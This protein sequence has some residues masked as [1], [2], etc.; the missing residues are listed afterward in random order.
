MSA[1]K[2]PL[3]VV[4]L[5]SWYPTFEDSIKGN[6]FKEQAQGLLKHGV[7]IGV[8]YPEIRS[9]KDLSFASVLKNHFQTTIE[10]ENK[11]PT[12]RL[13]GWNLFP[14]MGK[15][16]MSAW[17]KHALKLMDNYVQKRGKPELIHAHSVMWGGIAA[18]AIA[19]K[20]HIPYMI[21]EH[22]TG[23]Q[24][25]NPL[26]SPLNA[27]WSTPYLIS[28]Y[29]QASCVLAVGCALKK[30]IESFVDKEVQV[31][32]NFFDD[33]F[34]SLKPAS[35]FQAP[36]RY[37]CLAQLSPTK[38]YPL[39]LKAFQKVHAYNNRVSLEI[40]GSGKIRGQLEALAQELGIA[41][42]VKFLGGLTRQE[43]LAAMHRS[44]A[45][46]LSSNVETF[47]IVVIEALATGLPVI[48]TKSGGPEE[49]I[50]DEVGILVPLHDEAA[51]AKGMIDLQL[52]YNR[53]VK[54]KLRSSAVERYSQKVIIQKLIQKYQ[55][56][57]RDSL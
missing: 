30:A 40:G 20:Y 47:G 31:L 19:E 38:N 4:W 57:T 46:V 48:A 41:S 24:K 11:I 49:I 3:H 15:S 14:K 17:V 16:Q 45:F 18:Q 21:T 29:Q 5:P 9:L 44:D 8:I 26:G 42:S 55:A 53:Y 34:F 43:A 33:E 7:N 28:A 37:F 23:I 39:L 56:L 22:F 36:F 51:L 50:N 6:F 1:V 52:N 12:F 25:L 32:P 10:D 13:H 35:T 2:D 27:C 54:E